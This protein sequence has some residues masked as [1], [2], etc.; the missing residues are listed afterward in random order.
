MQSPDA[1]EGKF[2]TKAEKPDLSTSRLLEP[3]SQLTESKPA[4]FHPPPP[5]Q[6]RPASGRP[7]APR[8]KRLLGL[9]EIM[10]ERPSCLL[11]FGH[12]AFGRSKAGLSSLSVQCENAAR[13]Q[14]VQIAAQDGRSPKEQSRLEQELRFSSRHS[15]TKETAAE[16]E[17]Q[18]RYDAE[19]QTDSKTS[20][21][22][23]TENYQPQT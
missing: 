14:P 4:H 18:S 20:V 19:Y 16:Q 13:L 6:C 17:N 9:I 1:L 2:H 10:G 15:L 11:F 21:S 5:G 12:S 7:R 22:I 8:M 3:A 23:D